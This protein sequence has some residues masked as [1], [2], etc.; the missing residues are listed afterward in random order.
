LHHLEQRTPIG[1]KDL[2]QQF[3]AGYQ[4]MWRWRPRFTDALAEAVAA[5]PEAR[6]DVEDSHIVLHPSPPPVP[7]LANG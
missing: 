4:H 6:V 3:G 7:K 5:Y 2:Y 1:W